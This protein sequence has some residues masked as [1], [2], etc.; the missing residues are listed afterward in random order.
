MFGTEVGI[1][2]SELDDLV[3]YLII[4]S[5]RLIVHSV[6][7]ISKSRRWLLVYTDATPTEANVDVSCGA[8]IVPGL[9]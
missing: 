6:P 3:I 9:Q 5:P 2:Q 4:D 7:R 8:D 1:G